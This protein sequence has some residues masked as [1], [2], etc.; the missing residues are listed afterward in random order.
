MPS[1]VYYYYYG[2]SGVTTI[3]Y[4][5]KCNLTSKVKVTCGGELQRVQV[6]LRS[7]K[8]M[9]VSWVELCRSHTSCV[10]LGRNLACDQLPSQIVHWLKHRA[11]PHCSGKKPLAQ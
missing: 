5:Y 10:T 3:L 2:E 6:N 1:V 7:N 4:L 11:T 9:G 8:L